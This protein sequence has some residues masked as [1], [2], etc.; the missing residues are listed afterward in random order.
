MARRVDLKLPAAADENCFSLTLELCDQGCG[1]GCRD[2]KTGAPFRRTAG[3]TRIATFTSISTRYVRSLSWAGCDF[4]KLSCLQVDT[5]VG[6]GLRGRDG[7]RIV[8]WRRSR[9]ASFG[10]RQAT[11]N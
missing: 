9:R 1:G 3:S 11:R 5:S 6:P 10:L 8:S 4:E 2:R 7:K